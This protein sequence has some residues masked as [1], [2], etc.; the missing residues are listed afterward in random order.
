LSTQLEDGSWF[1]KS[2]AMAFQPYFDAGFPHGFD[3]WISTAGT[4]WTT[5]ALSL[6]SPARTTLAPH[7][8]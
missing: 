4:N 1:V 2:R 8:R 5:M 7:G 6:A 3:Q